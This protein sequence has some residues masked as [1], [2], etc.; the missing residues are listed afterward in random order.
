MPSTCFVCLEPCDVR[1]CSQCTLCAHDACLAAAVRRVHQDGTC[2]VC[3]GTLRGAPHV[4]AYGQTIA[5]ALC[6]ATFVLTAPYAHA[7]IVVAFGIVGSVAVV[8]SALAWVIA[9]HAVGEQPRHV[10]W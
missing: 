8:A 2:A 3:G 5:A 10:W 6:M 4:V 9:Y 7:G 1:A